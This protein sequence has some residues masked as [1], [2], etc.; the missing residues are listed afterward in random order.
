MLGGMSMPI[1]L[2]G[3]IPVF[4]AEGTRIPNERPPARPPQVI[5]ESHRLFREQ[6][7]AAKL[8]SVA[9]TYNCAGMVLAFRRTWIEDLANVPK[10]LAEDGYKPLKP[11]ESP[12]PGD[13]VVYRSDTGTVAHL[14]IVLEVPTTPIEAAAGPLIMSKWGQNGEYIHRVRDKPALLGSVVE[15]WTERQ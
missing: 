15:V 1:W 9:S 10:Y 14:G 5:R 12:A 11:N 13:V 8:R 7:P 3:E 2:A 4:T 6:H